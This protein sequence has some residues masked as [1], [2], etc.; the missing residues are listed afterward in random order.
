LY[1]GWLREVFASRLTTNPSRGRGH[2][3]VT[4]KFWQIIDISETVQDR[5]YYTDH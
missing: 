2:G 5:C 1:T 4:F 3:D